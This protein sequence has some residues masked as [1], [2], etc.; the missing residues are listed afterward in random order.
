MVVPTNDKRLMDDERLGRLTRLFLIYNTLVSGECVSGADLAG[1]CGVTTRTLRRDFEAL[2]EAG[3]EVTYDFKQRGYVLERPLECLQVEL[4]LDD[5]LALSL[6]QGAVPPGSPHEVLARR[7]FA[8]LLGRLPR[9]LRESAQTAQAA[10][11]PASA[12]R[13]DYQAAPWDELMKAV[14]RRETLNVHYYSLMSDRVSWRLIDPYALTMPQGYLQFVGFCH[15][16]GRVLHFALDGVLDLERTG[17]K[18]LFQPGFSLAKWLENSLGTMHGE[19][20]DIVVRFDSSRARWARRRRWTFRHSL[21]ADGDGLILR[22][23]V[24]GLEE[25]KKELLTWG[26]AVEVLEPTELREQ[27]RAESQAMAA[28]YAQSGAGGAQ[29]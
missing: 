19:A 26:A 5:L 15:T 4:S 29:E 2:H 17:Q 14:T 25:I 13:R 6:A 24:S 20:H 9:S 18:F 12:T 8:K 27:M 23:T 21:E 1:R 28:L 16:K 11:E 10:V 22:G 3:A 7:A